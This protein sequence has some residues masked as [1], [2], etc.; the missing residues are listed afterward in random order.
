VS[1]WVQLIGA[2]SSAVVAI[3]G[4]IAAG[5]VAVKRVS[6]KERKEAVE[7]AAKPTVDDTQTR[8]IEELRK[9]LEEL[10]GGAD[11]GLGD[12]G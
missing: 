2:I 4:A 5:I 3:I 8:E 1:D 12:D 6:P 11:A 7:E 9:K 10:S